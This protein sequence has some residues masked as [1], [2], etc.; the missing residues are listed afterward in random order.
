VLLA[1]DPVLEGGR[2]LSTGLE[3]MLASEGITVDANLVLELDPAQLVPP[4]NPPGP[5]VVTHFSEH[6]TTSLLKDRGE[7]LVAMLR[8]VRPTE[9]S[10][11]ETV[12]ETSETAWGE[13]DL[14]GLEGG[15]EPERD[16]GEV[17]GPVSL[18]V[19]TRV[20]APVEEGEDDRG[21]RLL[22]VGD[23]DWLMSAPLRHPRLSNLDLSLAFT[24][25]LTERNALISIPA[26][27]VDAQPMM[28]TED[29]LNGLGL[30]LLL[31]ALSPFLLGVAS[32]WSRRA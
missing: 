17:E 1:L 27:K 5:F 23:A 22:V 28:I 15:A 25:W 24:G 19:A 9:G 20:G 31:M 10:R 11:A 8:S 26:K 6:P 14:S 3:A 32:W 18:G 12:M 7:V 30:R 29:D 4:G 13:T 21:G 2:I 16:P